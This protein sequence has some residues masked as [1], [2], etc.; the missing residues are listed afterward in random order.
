MC[1]V[2]DVAWIERAVELYM[3]DDDGLL[4][5]RSAERKGVRHSMFAMHNVMVHS[6]CP[7]AV[8]SWSS[9]RR[10]NELPQAVVSLQDSSGESRYG[11]RTHRNWK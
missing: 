9:N 1:R 4:R 8:D 10:I 5:W 2:E 6:S 3:E 11:F 7:A